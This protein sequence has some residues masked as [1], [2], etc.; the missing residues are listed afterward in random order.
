MKKSLILVLASIASSLAQ[1]ADR[2]VEGRTRFFAEIPLA[3]TYACG[4]MWTGWSGRWTEALLMVNREAGFPPDI[5]Y[6]VTPQSL[7]TTLQEMRDYGLDG[8]IYNCDRPYLVDRIWEAEPYGGLPGLFVP[9]LQLRRLVP[10][11]RDWHRAI[12]TFPKNLKSPKGWY[13]RGKPV[14]V[15]WWE[16]RFYTP[17]KMSEHLKELRAQFGEFLFV[18]D[19]STITAWKYH[20][21]W[22]K[23]LYTEAD[24]E[25]M[26][27]NLRAY[28]RTTDGLY[29]GEYHALNRIDRGER[30]LDERYLHEVVLA[31]FGEVFNEPEFRDSGKLLGVS[32]GNGFGNPYTFG[33]N[34]GQDGTRT[35]RNSVRAALDLKPDFI[36]FFEWDEYNENTIIKPTIWNTFGLRRVIKAMTAEANGLRNDP[37][38][39]DDA[40]LPNLVISYRK[41][42]TPGEVADFEVLNVPETGVG[43]E[44][45]VQITVRDP[46]GLTVRQFPVATLDRAQMKDARFSA[47]SEDWSGSAALTVELKVAADGRERVFTGLAPIE[48]RAGGTWDHKWAVQSLRDVVGGSSCALK[49]SP[50][51]ETGVYAVQVEAESAEEID[52]VE[53]NVNGQHVF[54]RGGVFDDFRTTP[55]EDVFS[56]TAYIRSFTRAAMDRGL[57]PRLTVSGVDAAEWRIADKTTASTSTTFV[58]Q[59][60]YTPDM[61]LRLPRG[62]AERA[63]LALDWPEV[64]NVVVRL[65]DVIAADGWAMTDKGGFTFAVSKFYGFNE[66]GPAAKSRSVLAS[67]LVR[68]D[69][70]VS[71]VSAYLVTKGGKLFRSPPMVVGEAG[72]CRDYRVYSATKG[73]AVTVRM[74]ANRL[75]DLAY[76]FGGDSGVIVK[77]G[78]GFQT[79]GVLGTIPYVA[80]HRNRGGASFFESAPMEGIKSGCAPDTPSYAPSIETTDKGPALR[81]DGRDAFFAVPGAVIPRYA[82]YRLSFEFKPE[83]ISREQELFASG[84][85]NLYGP[86]GYVKIAKGRASVLLCGVNNDDTAVRAPGSVRR[87]EWNRLELVMHG[88]AVELVLNGASSGRLK[89]AVPGRTDTP[90]WFGGRQGKM[91]VGLLR[92]VKIDYL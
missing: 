22:L 79:D 68:S 70:P 47:A 48:M 16:D 60:S 62:A 26:R 76:E 3:T 37:L 82:A 45:A 29:F 84:T 86:V 78:G 55:T 1:S 85:R 27:A 31:R 64:T 44:V 20:S 18:S 61:Y 56:V 28:L 14:F 52:R 67:A 57:Y 89:C 53:V 83:D 54:T 58:A 6:R 81:F 4:N 8:A 71:V 23:G 63:T 41:T 50:A 91:F 12:A 38:P 5:Y 35:L 39:G 11:D 24:A 33:N 2:R 15:S 88:D 36:N 51:G 25:E 87:G 32:A 21:K 13:V 43:G 66:Y 10:T 9:S 42:L 90:S 69:L 92:D 17:E 59:A 30:V 40:S 80:T 49:V 77:S 34:T 65:K 74:D 73:E 7:I 72:K 46:S 19:I 75:P